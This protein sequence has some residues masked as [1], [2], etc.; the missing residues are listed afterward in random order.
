[1]NV[2]YSHSWVGGY[3]CDRGDYILEMVA[4]IRV[5]GDD[6]LVCVWLLFRRIVRAKKKNSHTGQ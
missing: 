1:M 4:E 6:A 3:T 5:G 2:Y